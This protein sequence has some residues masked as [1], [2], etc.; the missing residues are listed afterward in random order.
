MKKVDELF[1]DYETTDD[2]KMVYVEMT[3]TGY[4]GQKVAIAADDRAILGEARG[5]WRLIRKDRSKQLYETRMMMAEK[6]DALTTGDVHGSNH[7][8]ET[9]GIKKKTI[10]WVEDSWIVGGAEISGRTV[11][12]IGE[13]CGFKIDLVTP[14]TDPLST[15]KAFSECD[16]IVLNNFWGFSHEQMAVILRAIEGKPYVKYEHDH[17]EIEHE[18][19]I[20]K[21]LFQRSVLN[22]FLSPFH[23]S[24]HSEKFG[25][26]GI[27]LPLAIDVEMFKPV[28]GIERKAGSALVS[29]VRPFKT[30]KE[31]REFIDAHPE[32]EFTV[33]SDNGVAQG[34]DGVIGGENIKVHPIVPYETMPEMYSRFEYLVHLM[35]GWGAGERVIFEAALCGCKISANERVGHM[36]WRWD[37]SDT[38]GLR[39]RLRKA[40]FQ[41]W[42]SICNVMEW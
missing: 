1:K 3:L 8:Y 16:L 42:K 18:R 38:E 37:L 14:K 31:L 26:D 21:R 22:I 15:E 34:K 17:R 20:S 30:Y 35:D 36:S 23:C 10:A 5:K 39:E 4:G 19:E 27:C 24:N 9:K 41:F 11:K 12:M 7:T 28:A 40:P 13:D 32:M 2:G 6:P 29:N 25:I 33:L